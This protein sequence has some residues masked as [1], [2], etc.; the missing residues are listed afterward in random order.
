MKSHSFAPLVFIGLLLSHVSCH[1]ISGVVIGVSKWTA[2]RFDAPSSIA[3]RALAFYEGLKNMGVPSVIQS[4][5]DTE[6]ITQLSKFFSHLIVLEWGDQFLDHICNPMTYKAM[7]AF[8]TT[9][10]H[11]IEGIHRFANNYEIKRELNGHLDGC[12]LLSTL[13]FNVKFTLAI[14]RFDLLLLALNEELPSFRKALKGSNTSVLYVPVPVSDKL[15]KP[16]TKPKDF[17]RIYFDWDN[18]KIGRVDIAVVVLRAI[19]IY[20]SREETNFLH[21]KGVEVLT[22]SSLPPSIANYT[23]VRQITPDA[24]SG[25]ITPKKFADLLS[26]CHMYATAIHSTYENP[27]VESQMAGA[28]LVSTP[29]TVHRE[30][31]DDH[32]VIM[33]ASP[34]EIAAKMHERFS[35]RE[36]ISDQAHDIYSWTRQ[37]HSPEAVICS[38]FGGLVLLHGQATSVNIINKNSTNNFV[39]VSTICQRANGAEFGG[40]GWYY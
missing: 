33:N 15:W 39:P 4:L 24:G 1:H 9:A 21:S 20:R 22:V 38:F 14:S 8:N 6:K 18:R 35:K 40:V 12:N 13:P 36:N 7:R 32:S 10:M 27:V 25:L 23:T 16:Y 3:N 34:E 28:V 2:R 26:S 19:E 37:R 31:Y 5:S 17:I 30:L 29:L 11:T